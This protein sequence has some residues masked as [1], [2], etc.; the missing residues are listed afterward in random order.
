MLF[1][2]GRGHRV[3]GVRHQ[4]GKV[5]WSEQELPQRQVQRR[6]PGG[7]LHQQTPVEL[8]LQG[9]PGGLSDRLRQ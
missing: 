6:L 1:C 7:S 3:P 8:H 2:S 5:Q 9:G 4:Q